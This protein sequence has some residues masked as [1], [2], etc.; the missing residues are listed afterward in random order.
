[1]NK[2]VLIVVAAVAAL[3]FAGCTENVPYTIADLYF[4]RNDVAG[5]VPSKITDVTEFEKYFNMATV[6]GENGLPTAI[7]FDSQYVISV[8]EPETWKDTEIT[9]VSLVREKGGKVVFTYKVQSGED[10]SYSIVPCC[11]LVV[12]KKFDG[13]VVLKQE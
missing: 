6:M 2:I 9:P 11:I 3:M 10:R 5:E 13:D 1:M 12:D 8:V 7:D 4:V